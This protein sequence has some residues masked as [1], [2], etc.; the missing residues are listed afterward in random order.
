MALQFAAQ[1]V[2]RFRVTRLGI[3]DRSEDVVEL[4]PG[5]PHPRWLP[6]FRWATATDEEMEAVQPEAPRRDLAGLIARVA[7]WLGRR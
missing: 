2:M 7:R 3:G 4:T 6:G 1:P 5:G